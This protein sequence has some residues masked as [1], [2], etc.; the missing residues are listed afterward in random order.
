MCHNVSIR[1]TTVIEVKK[2]IISDGNMKVNSLVQYILLL[3]HYTEGCTSGHFTM[4]EVKRSGN[5]MS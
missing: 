4:T 2:C 5:L 3:R 1:N